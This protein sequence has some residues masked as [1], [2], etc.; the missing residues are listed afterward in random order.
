MTH[1]TKRATEPSKKRDAEPPASQASEKQG[2]EAEE[3][4]NDA[5]KV[6]KKRDHITEEDLRRVDLMLIHQHIVRRFRVRQPKDFE[7]LLGIRTKLAETLQQRKVLETFKKDQL[8]EADYVWY[9]YPLN[10]LLSSCMHYLNTQNG[11][12]QLLKGT[13]ESRQSIQQKIKDEFEVIISTVPAI[14]TNFTFTKLTSSDFCL[15]DELLFKLTNILAQSAKYIN[16]L[17]ERLN[18]FRYYSPYAMTTFVPGHLLY[19][20]YILASTKSSPFQDDL[21]ELSHQP[22]HY[23]QWMHTQNSFNDPVLSALLQTTCYEP[24]ITSSNIQLLD[25][26]QHK[27]TIGGFEFNDRLVLVIP[28]H[29]IPDKIDA[30]LINLRRALVQVLD[31]G[32]R[33]NKN[34]RWEHWEESRFM[35]TG[36]YSPVFLT[37]NGKAFSKVL[38]GLC[39]FDEAYGSDLSIID[40]CAK[41]EKMVGNLKKT[42]DATIYPFPAKT[43]GTY[44]QETNKEINPDDS[45]HQRIDSFLRTF[46]DIFLGENRSKKPPLSG[47]NKRS[48]R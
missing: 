28:K 36:H 45:K 12:D 4:K 48:I 16:T 22:D 26:S 19:R 43:L 13:S 3:K 5:H 35:N 24:Q 47:G 34:D 17:R 2:A 32:Y 7:K 21:D 23:A 44:Y 33:E 41:V 11:I 15:T 18:Y 10:R 30:S 27:L 38:A 29:Q 31:E 6:A 9:Y 1:P 8:E 40:A 42:Y 20:Q 37:Q 39:V 14:F 25:S 46:P